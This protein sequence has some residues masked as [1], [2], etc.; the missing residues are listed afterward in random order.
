M[1][2]TRLNFVETGTYGDMV[3]RPY[4]TSV[5]PREI[6]ILQEAT[7]NGANLNP[8]NLA[9]VAGSIIRPCTEGVGVASIENGWDTKRLRFF[10]EVQIPSIAGA[11]VVQYLTGYTDHVGVSYNGTI[12]PNMRMYFNNSIFARKMLVQTPFGQQGQTT[13]SDASQILHGN[14]TP[15]FRNLNSNAFTMRPEDVFTTI[16]ASQMGNVDIVDTRPSFATSSLKKSRRSNSSPTTYLSRVMTAHRDT[17][18]DGEVDDEYQTAMSRAVGRVRESLVSQ[19]NTLSIFQRETSLSEGSSI[20]YGELCHLCPQLDS[21]T[22]VALATGVIADTMHTR[23]QSEYWTSTTNEAIF[24]TILTHSVPAVM[25]DLMINKVA[26]VATNQTL[27]GSF[28]IQFGE[29]LSFAENQDMTPYI[30][31]FQRRLISEIFQDLTRNNLIDIQL[32]AHF[33]VLGETVMD[34]SLGGGPTVR[35]VSPSFCDGL[36]SPV[37]TN[38]AQFLKA[39]SSDID[40]LADNMQMNLSPA[41]TDYP[42]ILQGNSN[43]YLDS[44]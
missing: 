42:Q 2:I 20:T 6:S 41:N 21:L 39:M 29:V 43:G 30:Q 5:T 22:R 44:I 11:V 32:T 40:S 3:I 25:M 16:S 7:D 13:V 1:N 37:L 19:D 4:T 10:M 28:Q 8:A 18:N 26:F 38:D 34:I 17:F 27:D 35:F 31:Q 14:Y 15:S 12:D 33:D 9:G 23:G 24:C 36:T